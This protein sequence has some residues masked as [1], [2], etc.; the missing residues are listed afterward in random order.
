MAY[1]P[2]G[3]PDPR[4]LQNAS[5]LSL[6]RRDAWN[7]LAEL[8]ARLAEPNVAEPDALER[9]IAGTVAFLRGVEGFWV[10]PGTSALDRLEELA[11]LGHRDEL[12]QLVHAMV[13]RLG[14]SGD[15]GGLIWAAT[16]VGEQPDTPTDRHY[17]TA[18]IVSDVDPSV[19]AESVREMY[20]YRRHDDELIYSVV[21]VR[22]FDAALA[23][24]LLNHEIQA[25]IMRPDVPLRSG[26][27]FGTFDTLLDEYDAEFKLS[28][29][30]EQ[31][32]ARALAT[33]LRRVRPHL[34]LYLLTD[35]AL[36]DGQGLTVMAFERAFYRYESRSELHMTLMNGVRR[37]FSTPFF[38]ALKRYANKP[39]GN[40][41]A[42]PIARGNSLFGSP[43][44]RDMVS[45]YGRNIFLAETSTTSGGLDSL[46][47]PTGSL[48]EAQDKAAR[49]FGAV[50]TF[51][52]TNG[53]STS[54]KIVV[55]A[56]TKP[57]DVVLIDRNCHKSHHY[58]LILGGA[59]PVYLDAYK[60]PEF[61]MYGA[62]PLRTIKQT[63]LDLRR[64]GR[65]D[66]V[67][68]LLLTNCTFDGVTYDPLRVMTEVLAIKP[69][70]VFLWD[71][72]WFAFA[73]SSY[74]ARTRT[75]MAAAASL[76]ETLG[77]PEYRAKY[78]EHMATWSK[79]DPDDDATWLDHRLMPDPDKARV[80]VYATQST[81]KS[82]SALRQASMI[83]VNDQDFARDAE[84]ELHEA[85]LTHTSTS[86]NYQILASLDLARRQVD[87]EGFS[88]VERA[89]EVAFVLRRRIA[90]DPLLSRY[91]FIL[92]PS[93]LIPA[94]Y[95]Q[96]GIIG[97]TGPG[98]E[99]SEAVS[100][101]RAAWAG[102]EFVLE[103]TRATLY[104]AATGLNGDTF[105]NSVLMDR[106]GLQVNKTSINSVLFIVTIGATWGALSYLLESL[107]S[108]A[109]DLRVQQEQASPVQLKVLERRV[110]ALSTDLPPL[111]DFSR[112]HERFQPHPGS[113]E[114]DM[115][116]AYFLAYDPANIDYVTL[117]E[118]TEQIGAGRQLVSTTLVVPYPP[119]F[120]VLVPGQV[121]SKEILD[122]LTKLDVGEIH[123][124]D[125]E[126][127]LSVFTD[128]ALS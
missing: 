65:L 115:R 5:N 22:S 44:M 17:F 39:I 100:R 36:P 75:G 86:P 11:G 103:P 105:K 91:F 33:V 14:K 29:A 98:S 32:R 21:G 112:F 10:F 124:Y 38:D 59:H 66:S 126:L 69:D 117:A 120:P 7:H 42:L 60:L 37:R 46:L 80:R 84:A 127:G 106:F 1:T 85:F 12:S 41:H 20:S 61:A 111:P 64:A 109:Q 52:S 82:L 113:P 93:D 55:Q 122:F 34:D 8:A 90:S 118:A 97:F 15:E 25:V 125:P 13:W 92:E 45:F 83:H 23:C 2:I 62:V 128:A 19:L 3:Q 6:S 40:F 110:S 89:Y 27:A 99:G 28:A 31:R 116:A 74:Y 107:T 101:M 76:R 26:T 58:G 30:G 123:G 79:L 53:T 70:M 4:F 50:R 35:E 78:A 87:L 102:D 95:R 24:V 43:W 119:G 16:E 68:M 77:T 96:S 63:L 48:K 81:H 88:L 54:N 9:Q 49:T 72:A 67:R 94:E 18:L 56:L 51:Y 73:V 47:A 71:E 104:L 108:I 121:V 57:G 114:G